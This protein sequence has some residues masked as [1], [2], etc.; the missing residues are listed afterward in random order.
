MTKTN[1][2]KDS[3]EFIEK[4]KRQWMA[5]V[6]A[7]V[8]PLMIVDR[9]YTIVK[10]NRA[11]ALHAEL[12]ITSVVGAKCYK[13]FAGRESPCPGCQ[14][15]KAIEINQPHTYEL[16]RVVGQKVHEVISQ[17]I[18]DS[19]DEITGVVQI[20]R[21]R[22]EA[23]MLW[24][25]LL[26]SEKL[27]SIGLLAGGIAH[28]IN[29]PLGGILIFAQMLLREMNKETSHYQDVIEIEA[30]AQ[31]CKLIVENLLQFA[32]KPTVS[33]GATK[34][35]F[36]IKAALDDALKFALV[37]GR[38]KR[39]QIVKNYPTSMIQVSASRNKMTQV[40]LNLLQNA[41]Q[42]MP[43]S[44][45]LHLKIKTVRQEGKK[46]L[47]IEITD[48]GGGIP[49]EL[50][51]KIFDPFFTTKEPSEGTGLGL[52][53]C[54]GIIKDMGGRIEVSSVT[55]KGSSFTI[56]LPEFSVIRTKKEVRKVG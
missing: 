35:V 55:G 17:P 11:T 42:A 10:A 20:Y 9:D 8:D 23:K 38:Q 30:A 31:R 15:T 39:Y 7:I 54:H 4:L 1:P 45:K 32:R 25:R 36:D 46:H 44:G 43:R 6:D 50:V 22:T 49:A 12:P 41:M 19:E 16:S 47:S 51:G 29:N 52:S 26:Q 33:N 40:F 34:E 24:E 5:T 56:F 21:D 28:E 14:M 27:A 48:S 37:G 3:I 2:P 13:I 18:Y 53:I